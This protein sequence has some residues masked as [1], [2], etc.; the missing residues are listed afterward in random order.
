MPESIREYY[1]FWCPGT[2]R[3]IKSEILEVGF[4]HQLIFKAPR[5]SHHATTFKNHFSRS[6]LSLLSFEGCLHHSYS[7]PWHIFPLFPPFWFVHSIFQYLLASQMEQVFPLS[8]VFSSNHTT[9]LLLFAIK[10][11]QQIACTFILHLITHF[12][13]NLASNSLI[14]QT[15]FQKLQVNLIFFP[16]FKRLLIVLTSSFFLRCLI[17][18]T[19]FSCI[20]QSFTLSSPLFI[21]IFFV[22]FPIRNIFWPFPLLLVFFSSH[23]QLFG[24]LGITFIFL[25]QNGFP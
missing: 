12:V 14:C 22:L 21:N 15:V 8:M 16:Q 1:I 19:M 13:S 9:C 2:S 6:L 25:W 23:F 7:L 18:S 20:H 17:S 11:V 24:D 10:Y 5:Q 3:P 4:R